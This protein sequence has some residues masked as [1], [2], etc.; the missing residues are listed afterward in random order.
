[1]LT[2]D[3]PNKITPDPFARSF[4]RAEEGKDGAWR[5]ALIGEDDLR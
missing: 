1:V 2:G 3:W 5:R 4:R